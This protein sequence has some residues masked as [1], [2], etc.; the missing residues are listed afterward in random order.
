MA[1]TGPQDLAWWFEST[2][3]LRVPVVA[4]VKITVSKTEV[5]GSN[6]TWDTES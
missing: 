6:P 2:S 4:V 5:V 1:G 3:D